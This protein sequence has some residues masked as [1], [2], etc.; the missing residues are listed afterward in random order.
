MQIL[1]LFVAHQFKWIC[2]RQGTIAAKSFPCSQ[3][4]PWQLSQLL[5]SKHHQT[6]AAHLLQVIESVQVQEKKTSWVIVPWTL[7]VF[8]ASVSRYSTLWRLYISAGRWIQ[9]GVRSLLEDSYRK[10]FHL[11]HWYVSPSVCTK[12]SK[13]HSLL[14]STAW[15]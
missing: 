8:I 10:L 2:K 9:Q 4:P 7:V 3:M 15:D 11:R 13:P 6:D 5:T 14:F 12:S 1:F